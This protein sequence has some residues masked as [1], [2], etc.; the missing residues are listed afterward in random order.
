MRLSVV[1][2]DAVNERVQHLVCIRRR[3]TEEVPG[4]RVKRKAAL[5]QMSQ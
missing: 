3:H 5:R 2:W 1:T 4:L